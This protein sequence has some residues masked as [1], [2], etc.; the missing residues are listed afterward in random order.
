MKYHEY[1]YV[2]YIDALQEHIDEAEHGLRIKFGDPLPRPT[3]S[4]ERNFIGQSWTDGSPLFDPK[5]IITWDF[6][7]E[8]ADA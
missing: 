4:Y 3:F 8:K 2:E 1:C 6:P 7:D 5:I